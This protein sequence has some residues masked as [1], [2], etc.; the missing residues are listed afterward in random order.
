MF[1]CAGAEAG[2][3]QTIEITF[4]SITQELAMQSPGGKAS[5]SD[6]SSCELNYRNRE[7]KHEEIVPVESLA[8]N[9]LFVLS[10]RQSRMGF[11]ETD[12]GSDGW[13]LQDKT[14]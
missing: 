7:R 9:V 14:G 8:R 11:V 12:R 1:I 2:L 4:N 13:V 6:M 5:T 10:P 3:F